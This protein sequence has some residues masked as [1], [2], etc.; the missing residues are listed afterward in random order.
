VGAIKPGLFADLIVLDRNPFKVPIT[1]VHDTK[2]QTAM[3][4]G[5]VVYQAP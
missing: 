4:N 1:T 5:D 2:V 3:I